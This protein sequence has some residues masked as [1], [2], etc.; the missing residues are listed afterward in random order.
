MK[1]LTRVPAAALVE[2]HVRPY[3]RAR[4]DAARAAQRTIAATPTRGPH[5]IHTPPNP[6]EDSDGRA[7]KIDKSS[8]SRAKAA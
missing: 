1:C 8:R 4:L 5:T 2:Q 6:E 7:E 3:T